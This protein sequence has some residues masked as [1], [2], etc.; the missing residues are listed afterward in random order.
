MIGKYLAFQDS[1][2]D[3][4]GRAIRWLTLLMI[5]VLLYE[6][7]SRSLFG[8][9]TEW[10]HESST[11]LYGTLCV[12]AGAY[13]MRHR[14]HVRSDVLYSHFSAR[15][16][17]F[18]DTL[19]LLLTLVCMLVFFKLSLDFAIESWEVREISSKSTWRPPI[20]PF[21][22]VVPI[23]VGL[24]VLQLLAEL[25]RSISHMLGVE[26]D[27]PRERHVESGD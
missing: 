4:V 12:L 10:A 21:K 7:A 1:L 26:I 16:K 15:A 2:S 18:C 3:F 22:S 14:G 17:G 19:G 5:G 9:P 11:M 23:A 6:I 25:V 27:D 24:I 13:T 20:Y 8:V